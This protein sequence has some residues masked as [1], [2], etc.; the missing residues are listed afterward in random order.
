MHAP[1][2]KS[3][4]VRAYGAV[5]ALRDELVEERLALRDVLPPLSERLL[6]D[7][8]VGDDVRPSDAS[9][10]LEGRLLVNT[11]NLGGCDSSVG[12]ETE[13]AKHG[14]FDLADETAVNF[15][16]NSKGFRLAAIESPGKKHNIFHASC[17]RRTSGSRPLVKQ[18]ASEGRAVV[19]RY[20]SLS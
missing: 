9:R 20:P 12:L 16:H 18:W 3:S 14:G 6:E 19:E 15:T 1:S 5:R 2:L 4:R 7:A 17:Q 11:G 10:H 13:F 8:V